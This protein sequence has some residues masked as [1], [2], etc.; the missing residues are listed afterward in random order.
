VLKKS[1]ITGFE[2]VIV[3]FTKFKS[4]VYQSRRLL[5]SRPIPPAGTAS[6][7]EIKTPVPNIFIGCPL[8]KG[9]YWI[10]ISSS[11]SYFV[12]DINRELNILT[13]STDLNP[14]LSILEDKTCTFVKEHWVLCL[15]SKGGFIN[16]LDNSKGF[17]KPEI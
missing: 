4:P 5:Q 17:I 9:V 2:S 16:I 1:L 10:C 3:D 11:G 8:T 14:Q 15:G 13:F 12:F 6:Q 7:P